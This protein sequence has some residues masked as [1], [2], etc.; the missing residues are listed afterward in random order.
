MSKD[1]TNMGSEQT[2]GNSG[3]FSDYEFIPAVIVETD[4]P[5]HYGRLKVTALGS[6]NANKSP[7][8]HLPWCY[9]FTMT[10][11]ASYSSYE[12]GSKVWLIRNK[13]R[14]DENWFIPMYELHP[15]AQQFVNENS[16]N[17]PEVISLRNNGGGKSQIT[18]D[19]NSGY[20]ISASAGA[21]TSSMNV[22][23]D[24]T[25]SVNAGN[26]SVKVENEMVTIGSVGGESE[27]AV[28]G[29]K[30]KDL[31]YDIVGAIDTFSTELSSNDP[32]AGIACTNLK[33]SILTIYNEIET[34]LSNSVTINEKK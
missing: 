14:Q 27:P 9:P 19:H 26:S 4:D 29:Y 11:N 34:I 1:Y 25:S 8:S 20:N 28:L 23:T 33:N 18:Y 22:G 12:K 16:T 17:K 31:L 3:H 5:M 30:L 32:Y 10:G 24:G 21:G 15:Q 2:V 7:A 13:K 6:Y